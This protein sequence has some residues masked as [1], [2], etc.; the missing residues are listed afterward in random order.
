MFWSHGTCSINELYNA[1]FNCPVYSEL[2]IEVDIN[3]KDNKFIMS[4]NDYIN[5]IKT[6]LVLKWINLFFY[7]YNT[8]Y[9]T[10]NRKLILK[11]D[12]KNKLCIDYLQY[13]ICKKFINYTDIEIWL[14][15]DIFKGP[16]G[17]DP[18]LNL[19]D[20]NNIFKNATNLVLSVGYTTNYSPFYSYSKNHIINTLPDIINFKNKF[21][22][23][24][25][26]FAIRASYAVQSLNILNKLIYSEDLNNCSITFWTGK[27][28]I[29]KHNLKSLQNLESDN[30]YFYYDIQKVN[31]SCFC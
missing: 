24:H 16:G 30:F 4:H 14:N 5:K 27:E 17:K 15:A 9:K 23:K 7:L 18:I 13:Y 28:G 3:Y 8:Y 2:A 31:F 12:I 22:I 25:V 26:T 19:N 11:F 20:F 1:F 6:P 29:S 21:N 10:H